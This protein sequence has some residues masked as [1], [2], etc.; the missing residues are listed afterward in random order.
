MAYIKQISKKFNMID[1][2]P[3]STPMVG[4]SNKGAYLYHPCETE[5]LL[6][7][8]LYPYL[9]AVKALFYL[10]TSTRPNIVF[11]INVLARYSAYP[12]L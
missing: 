7:E 4:Y 5:E 10:T 8:E 12:K 3:L 2:Y 1:A 6:G 9:T 11:A